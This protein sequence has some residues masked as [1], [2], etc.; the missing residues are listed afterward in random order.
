MANE[1]NDK[2]IPTPRTDA[3]RLAYQRRAAELGRELG[4]EDALEL[5]DELERELA[6]AHERIE[7]LRGTADRWMENDRQSSIRAERAEAKSDASAKSAITWEEA[8]RFA[9]YEVDE[10][11]ARLARMCVGMAEEKEKLAATYATNCPSKRS[12]KNG[13]DAL[14]RAA[15]RIT[16]LPH[17]ASY[18]AFVCK[19]APDIDP[20]GPKLRF[21]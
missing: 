9:Q 5:C 3:A 18:N 4:P 14:R 8:E 6:E 15:E 17:N 13:A 7:R 11:R 16:L 20:F 21:P 10:L 1:S 19:Q 2:G 12:L